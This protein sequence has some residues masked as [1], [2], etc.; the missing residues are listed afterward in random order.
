MH[1]K[2]LTLIGLLLAGCTSTSNN[3]NETPGSVTDKLIGGGPFGLHGVT[4]AQPKT[5][6]TTN[7][8]ALPPE[9]IET[10]VAQG[11]IPVENPATVATGS[12]MTTVGFYGYEGPGPML[13]APGDLPSATH[14]VEA[15][16]TEPDKNTY[17]V[18]FGQT[19]ADPTYDYGTHF[20][21][22][23]HEVGAAGYITRVNL[24]ADYAHKV[25]ILASTDRAG[26]PI[27]DIDG[28]TWDPFAQRLIFTTENQNAPTYQAT[29]GFPSLVEDISGAVGRG[30]YEGVQND[31]AGNLWI[32]EDIGGPTSMT[33]PHSKAPNSFIYRFVK[34]RSDDLTKGKLQVLQVISLQ[35][36]QPITFH[37]ADDASSADTF[38]LRTYG[39][40]FTTNWITI[41][42]TDVDG[43][44]PFNAN[45]A[46]KA[47]GGTPFKRP[48]N[49]QFRP[50]TNFKEF[51]F[52]ETGD[53][54]NRS[55][56]GAAGGGFG[57]IFKLTQSSPTANSGTL[58]LFFQ[59]DQAHSGFDNVT[60][61]SKNQ[62]VFVEDAGDTLHTQ[63]NALDSAYAF[64]V[65]LDYSNAVNQPVRLIGEGRDPSA[66]LDS[67]FGGMT[68]F[69]NEGDNE[70]T[71]I[72]MS[73]GDPAAAGILGAKVPK[74]FK[75]GWRLFY[76]GQHG[77]NV[78]WEVL[79]NP[80]A[81]SLLT[82]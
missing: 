20:L 5:P 28:S 69:N 61:L 77:D 76:T 14:L 12:T 9:L 58:T 46:A 72:H 32:V 40:V 60:F 33:T 4:N 49:A 21:Y 54:D 68:G 67:A 10:A 13:P 25:T 57:S 66:T 34:K 65:T 15:Q 59:C 16:K 55:E 64:D 11:S 1:R 71:G 24:D 29:L 70:I 53:T 31:S 26:A 19:G 38:D 17:L 79:L 75:D 3:G 23:G 2:K 18:L 35:N 48:E 8:N 51:F 27:A 42:D 30:G 73:D 45:V 41:H 81:P 22:Q 82:E 78:T 43:F 36:G 37:G 74:Q 56:V 52:D 39:K 7:P 47:K 62:V 6:G 63:R 44:A 80:T 50:G